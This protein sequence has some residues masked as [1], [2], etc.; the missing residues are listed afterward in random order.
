MMSSDVLSAGSMPAR[1]YT[2]CILLQRSNFVP[3]TH[4]S[5][6]TISENE[7]ACPSARVE[8]SETSPRL[9]VPIKSPSTSS[10]S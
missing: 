1:T 4:V 5:S 7:P 3:P 10:S 8:M 6:D 9:Q 2:I